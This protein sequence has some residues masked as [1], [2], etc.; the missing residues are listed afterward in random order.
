MAI[1]TVNRK[2]RK[3]KRQNVLLSR[4]TILILSG[5]LIGWGMGYSATPDAQ[6]YGFMTGII[7]LIAFVGL[8]SHARR[9]EQK[10]TQRAIERAASVLEDRLGRHIPS[11]PVNVPV[12]RVDGKLA[13]EPV[14]ASL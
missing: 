2:Q 9:Q 6:R 3:R 12:A 5:I 7:G 8:D 14:V 10:A 4:S 1:A 13:A 11:P